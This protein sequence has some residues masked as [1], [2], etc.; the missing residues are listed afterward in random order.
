MDEEVTERQE[1]RNRD[2]SVSRVDFCHYY[3]L[4][5]LFCFCCSCLCL[6]PLFCFVC[7]ENAAGLMGDKGGMGR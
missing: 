5:V 1:R 4:V 3:G 6:L 7:E 2:F